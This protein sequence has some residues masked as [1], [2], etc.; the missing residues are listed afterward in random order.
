[1]GILSTILACLGKAVV[2]FGIKL[3]ESVATEKFIKWAFFR[4]ARSV[5]ECTDT[6]HDDEWLDK[7]EEAYKEHGNV[8]G[9]KNPS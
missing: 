1:M 7:I 5:V 6:K 3:L 4:I 2:S 8:N 9:K